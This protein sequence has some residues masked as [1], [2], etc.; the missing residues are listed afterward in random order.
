MS[1]ASERDINAKEDTVDRSHGGLVGNFALI[2]EIEGAPAQLR[3]LVLELAIRAGLSS[4]EVDVGLAEAALRRVRDAQQRAVARREIEPLREMSA[5]SGEE[6]PHALPAGWVWSRLSQAVLAIQIGPF[7]SLLH[8][9]DYV[10]GGTPLV[11]PTNICDGHIVPDSKKSVSQSTL[12][13][14]DGYRVRA[15]DVVMGRRGEMGRCAVV[16]SVE[17]GWLCG[18]GSLLGADPTFPSSPNGQVDRAETPAWG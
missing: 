18:T 17:D 4:A 14:L 3:A 7:G 1:A 2:A 11:N 9:S 5:I 10:A 16:T 6:L 15:R 12:A 13:R 8:Q